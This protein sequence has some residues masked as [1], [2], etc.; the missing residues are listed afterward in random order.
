VSDGLPGPGLE[1]EVIER[2]E[3]AEPVVKGLDRPRGGLLRSARLAWGVAILALV[4]A[5]FAGTQ[6]ADLY[7]A[8]RTREEVRQEATS[9]VLSLTTFEG[10]RIED[11]VADA[12]SRATGEYAEQLSTLFDQGLRDA[13]R[14]QQVESR[15]EVTRL[16]VQD[17]DGDEAS[18]FALVRQT[19][20]NAMISDPVQDELRMDITM[21]RVDGQWLASDVAV[22][23][24]AGLVGGAPRAPGDDEPPVVGDDAADEEGE[25]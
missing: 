10:E 8:E 17:I 16:F 2:S 14:E 11:W 13:L 4:L 1:T 24:P 23:G 9:L 5:A 7:A 15:G 21:E 6:W 19:T 22:L 20:I 18:V 12:Q 25:Q 3:P